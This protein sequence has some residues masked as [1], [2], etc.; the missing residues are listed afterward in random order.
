[1]PQCSTHLLLQMPCDVHALVQD[2]HDP[3]TVVRGNVKYHGGLIPKPSQSRREFIGLAPMRRLFRKH[4]EPLVQAQQ[5]VI[6]PSPPN[7]YWT[8]YA[9][10]DIM[11]W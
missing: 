2:T 10:H 7:M 5:T 6:L 11:K 4:L 8:T 1:M 3:N 9:F